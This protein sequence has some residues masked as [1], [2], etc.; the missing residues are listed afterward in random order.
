GMQWI[1]H[2]GI[3][4]QYDCDNY[5]ERLMAYELQGEEGF[6]FL[7]ILLRKG[8]TFLDAGTNA[9]MHSAA[10]VGIVGPTGRVFSIEA[11]PHL[12]ARLKQ[13]TERNRT[14]HWT[15]IDRALSD[16]EGDTIEFH[17]SEFPSW[18]SM[19]P[20]AEEDKPRETIHVPTTTLDALAPTL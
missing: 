9:G 2:I 12:V 5:H 16:T 13:A 7:P 19:A 3:Q 15:I 10:A 14:P 20:L 6:A 11:N 17:L 1:A 8:D 18:S 4:T